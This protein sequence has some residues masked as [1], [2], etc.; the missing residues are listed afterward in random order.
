MADNEN[1][2]SN[3]YGYWIADNMPY[4][5]YEANKLPTKK[6]IKCKKQMNCWED[7]M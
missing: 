7:N 3:V 2:I 4:N 1:C 5:I 6:R